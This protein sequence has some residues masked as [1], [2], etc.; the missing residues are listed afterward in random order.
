[1]PAASCGDQ[2]GRA[3]PR[4]R[5]NGSSKASASFGSS[6]AASGRSDQLVVVG[7]VALGDQ[8]RALEL[9]EASLLEADREGADRLRRSRRRPAPRAPEESTPPESSTPTGTSATRWART[10]SRSALAQLDRRAASSGSPRTPLGA[11]PGAGARSAGS[12]TS[13]P[14]PDEQVARRAA[15]APRAKI[16]SGAGIE[17]KARKA[18]SASRSISREKPGCSSS[19]FSSEANESVAVRE[20]VVERL[21]P[22]AVAGQ[23][24]ARAR[25]GPRARSRTSRAA[26]STNAGA[27][28]LVEVDEHL[29]VAVGR[30]AV[31][32]ALQ[33]ARAARGSCRSRRSGPPGRVPSSLAIGWSPPSRSMIESRRAASADRPLGEEAVAVGAAV[34]EASR[35]SPRA[36]SGSGRP[37]VAARRGRRCRTCSGSLSAARSR[38]PGGAPRTGSRSSTFGHAVATRT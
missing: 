29:G 35:S 11:A 33:L 30:E 8:P 34:D 36:T 5:A 9:V 38:R 15:C 17:L 18:A 12:L 10:E 14:S 32:A 26:R 28:L 37:P 3:A 25:G 1:M 13:P 19:A 27:A 31:A 22:E 23:Q 21:D 16:V 2:V 7:P 24:Q 4:S 6:S 20:P